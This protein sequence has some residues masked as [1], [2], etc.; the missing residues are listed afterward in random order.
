[1]AAS[2]LSDMADKAG[3]EEKTSSGFYESTETYSDYEDD[4]E[5]GGGSIGFAVASLVCGILS[6]L[7]C[8]VC[9]MSWLFSIAA[10]VLG[11]IVVTKRY[12]GKG[13]AIG[14]IATGAVAIILSIIMLV[15]MVSQGLLESFM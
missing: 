6:I 15:A 3:E 5:E 14:G 13:L 7:C 12:D 2:D 11:I 4:T 9:C 1:Q 8:P 10:I